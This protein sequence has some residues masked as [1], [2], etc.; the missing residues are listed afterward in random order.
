[1]DDA[2]ARS[3]LTDARVAVLGTITPDGRPHLV[4]CCFVLDG[5]TIYTAVDTVKPKSTLALHRLE[6]IRANPAVSLLVQ[7]YAE[8]W[9]ALWWVRVDG[10]GRIVEEEDEREKALELL[11]S[12]YDQYRDSPA[13]GEVVA[14]HI[15]RWR[16]WP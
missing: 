9:T 12:R 13:P 8:D 1:M 2:T 10:R 5:D 15:E 11:G 6:N 4:P 3:R 7:H 14:L 16:W